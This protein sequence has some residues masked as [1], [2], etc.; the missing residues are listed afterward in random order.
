MTTV[1]NTAATAASSAER[2]PRSRSLGWRLTVP[3]PLALVMA[4]VLIW[5]EVPKIITG[6]A[7]EEAIRTSEQIAGQFKLIRAYYTENVVN[8]VVSKGVLKPSINH[9]TEEDGIPLPATMI[10][11]LSALLA[12][13]D[14]T[15]NLYSRFPFPNRK[16]RVLD[17]FQQEA[18]DF[19]NANP[20]AT[21]SRNEMR[22]GR[23]VVRVAVADTMAAQACVNCHNKHALSPKT[24]WKLGDVRG[25]LEVASVIDAQVANGRQLS[26]L[27]I[28]GAVAIGLVLL[29]I[30]LFTARSVTSP[31]RN[32]ASVMGAL[33]GHN[34][35]VEIKGTTRRDE[36]GEMA[37]AVVVFRDAAIEKNRLEGMT[38]EQRRAAEEERRRNEEARAKAAEEQAGVVRAIAAGLEKLARGDLSHR[39][40]EA[41]PAAY[42]Q[43]KDDFNGAMGQLQEA[44]KTI[45]RTVHGIQAGTSEFSQAADDLSKRTEQQA[46]SLEETAAAVDE[47]TATVRRTAEGA[48]HA[49]GIVSKAKTDAEQSGEV[50]RNAVSAMTEIEGSAK[51]ISQIIGVIDEIAFQTNLLALNAGVEAARAGEAGK[52]FAV[53]ASEVR[54]LAQRSAEAA[55]EIKGLISASSAQVDS[56]VELVGQ[57]GAALGRIVTQVAEINQLVSEIASSAQEQAT[58][59]AQVNTAVNQM[60]QVTQQN[61]AMVEETSAASHSLAAE[62]HQL[63][64]LVSK[65]NVGEMAVA[66]MVSV[67]PNDGKAKARQ[68]A[69]EHGSRRNGDDR[70][71]RPPVAPVVRPSPMLAAGLAGTRTNGSQ[72]VAHAL[73][74]AEA[75]DSW[76][77]F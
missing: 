54:A 31:L 23:H 15:I 1:S 20:G 35:D 67:R 51:Q 38:A 49:K 3:I 4:I 36:I 16:D 30:A 40:S 68:A 21:F 17:S 19:L 55:K 22:G 37:R 13:K 56:G 11:D 70:G 26:N 73:Q 27:I 29:A 71:S 43:L 46:A 58:G 62:A 33:A 34:N 6:N 7:T 66:E 42:Q 28:V 60:D 8:K 50:V 9:K 45:V 69:Q 63:A 76:A 10:H 65:F 32:L 77:E 74:S 61:A 2:L 59:L 39:V 57:T 47:I 52:G 41:F 44:M 25:V 14:T 48:N 53:V 5:F 75:E 64:Q 18:W 72:A 24:D 12:K